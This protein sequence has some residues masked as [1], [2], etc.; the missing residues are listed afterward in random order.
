VK[1]EHFRYQEHPNVLSQD[2]ERGDL[3]P[4]EFHTN[5]TFLTSLDE[6]RPLLSYALFS[7]NVAT[8]RKV[9]RRVLCDAMVRCALGEAA[10]YQ[11]TS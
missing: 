9:L 2:F 4:I 5:S 8:G 11:Y 10:D 3:E 1:D 6:K 7:H